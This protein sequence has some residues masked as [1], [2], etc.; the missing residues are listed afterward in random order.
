MVRLTIDGHEH[1]VADGL[2]V[3]E[4]ARGAGVDIPALCSDERLAP[5]GACRLC[6]VAVRGRARPEAACTTPVHDGMVVDT[7]TLPRLK[8]FAAHSSS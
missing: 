6:V 4:A 2:T 3:L 7:R 1:D 8:T 5:S